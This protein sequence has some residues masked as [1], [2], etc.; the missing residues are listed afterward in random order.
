MEYLQNIV[1]WEFMNEPLSRWFV[2]MGAFIA[3]SIA[4]GG[5]LSFMK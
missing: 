2:F 5:I 1:G 3:I 4:W